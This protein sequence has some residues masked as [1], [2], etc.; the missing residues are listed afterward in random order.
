M[1]GGISYLGV[2]CHAPLTHRSND[3]QIRRQRMNGNIETHLVIALACA[4]MCHS[5][6]SLL[7]CHLNQ[8][9]CDQWTREGGRER[10]LSLVNRSCLQ[11]GPYEVTHEIGPPIEHHRFDCPDL[12]G[13]GSDSR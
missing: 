12:L 10:I 4:A 13:A 7:T 5:Y 1:F 8:Q 6:G 2:A 9:A 11:S 3:L